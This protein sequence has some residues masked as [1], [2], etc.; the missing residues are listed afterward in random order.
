MKN[1]L[2]TFLIPLAA[3]S[4]ASCSK[5]ADFGSLSFSISGD[6]ILT[7]CTK[8]QVSDFTTIPAGSDFTITVTDSGD[9]VV[10]SGKTADLPDS[11]LSL[12]C[13]NYTASAAYGSS[14][15]EGADKPC[16]SGQTNFAITGGGNVHVTIPV[17]LK[18]CIVK[19]EGTDAF[20]NYFTSYEFT[21]KTGAGNTFKFSKSDS[22]AVFIDAYRFDLEG[23]L[24]NQGGTSF[25]FAKKTYSNLDEAT[26][27]TVKFDASQVGGVKVT[28][29]FNDSTE[30]VDLGTIELND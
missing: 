20:N 28:I 15:D 22:K 8:S 13:G 25:S 29:S 5:N 4:L 24:V 18:N 7:D 2:L 10:W 3:L 27:Y 23:T 14:A 9:K 17:S 16:F 30:T 26:C 12:K 6:V 19:L 21:M 1:F 11:K